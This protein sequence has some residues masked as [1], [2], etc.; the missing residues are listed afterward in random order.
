MIK[1]PLVR[2]FISASF[3]AGAFVWVAVSYFNVE[4]E[5][6]WVFLQLSVAFVLG[7]IILGLVLTPL[8]RLVN[9]RKTFLSELE[10]IDEAP[11]EGNVNA[12]KD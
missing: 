4:M 3:F 5:V 12:E 6:V 11:G 9:R 10:N 8:F 2:R 7:L 1:D